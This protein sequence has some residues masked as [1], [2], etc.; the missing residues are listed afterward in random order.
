[1]RHPFWSRNRSSEGWIQR[2]LIAA[3]RASDV[4][5]VFLVGACLDA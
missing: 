3:I 1:M 5:N 2:E 4:V